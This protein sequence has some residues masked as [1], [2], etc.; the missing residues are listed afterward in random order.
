MSASANSMAM[1][2]PGAPMRGGY[3]R[4]GIVEPGLKGPLLWSLILHLLL[5]GS[6][7][8]S[9]IFSHRGEL[10]GGPGGG[11]AVSVKL[12]GG[13]AGVPLPR[14]ET[15]TES[16]VVDES[17][18]LYKAEPK[19]K[20]KEI[21]QDATPIPKFKK[22]KQPFYQTR[23]SKILEDT[24][25]PPQN[26]V[27]YGQGGS[28]AVP[29]SSNSQFTLGAGGAT[30]AGMQFGGTGGG[31]FAGRFS[32]YVDAVRNRVATNWLQST[33]DPSLRWAPRAVVSF[34]ILRN[35][36]VTNIQILQSSGNA[37]VDLSAMRAIQSSNPMQA[38][39]NE[40]SG[41][42]VSVEFWFDFRR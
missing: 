27:P 38:L 40:Y 26:A 4:T 8:A 22:E 19:P 28:P 42:K 18:G 25:P 6:L 10:W 32:W 23:P 13:L 34:D 29:Y 35:G 33:I 1:Q 20:P 5:F 15:V 11:G 39:P 3:V 36:G 14:P 16:R 24:T 30:A 17:K 21:P 12:V 2:P 7:I 41:N 37:S 9:T 31:D